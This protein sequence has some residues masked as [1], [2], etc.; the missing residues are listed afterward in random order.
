MYFFRL[1]AARFT[2]T[3]FKNP[4]NVPTVINNGRRNN[5]SAVDVSAAA[6][7]ACAAM[8][9]A[10]PTQLIPAAESELILRAI[11][12]AIRLAAPPAIEYAKPPSPENS[13]AVIVTLVI[14]IPAAKP[15]DF[16]STSAVSTAIL[17]SPSFI[18]A[19]GGTTGIRYST[20]P[21]NIAN[22]ARSPAAAVFSVLFTTNH[23]PFVCIF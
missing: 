15:S 23:S 21:S 19:I 6:T 3:P 10:P 16:N 13:I 7:A 11:T 1:P 12:I 2:T 17:P 9:T 8:C 5:T 22:A 4:V 18:P 14:M 20:Y